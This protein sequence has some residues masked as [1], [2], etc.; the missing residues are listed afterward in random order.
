MGYGIWDM[1]YG[2]W[3]MGYRIWVNDDQTRTTGGRNEKTRTKCH[4]WDVGQ[5]WVLPN[6]VKLESSSWLN[7]PCQDGNQDGSL[8]KISES[9]QDNILGIFGQFSCYLWQHGKRN[10]ERFTFVIRTF[11]SV[12]F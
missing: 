10:E 6:W 9:S 2:I 5:S 12:L 3:D 1:G 8:P 7:C 11:H 4:V